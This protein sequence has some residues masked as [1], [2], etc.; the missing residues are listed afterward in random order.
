MF[1]VT[2]SIQ[3][4]STTPK[5]RSRQTF[6]Q[7]LIGILERNQAHTTSQQ[8]DEDLAFFESLIPAVRK[9]ND[10][11]KTEFR[12]EVL[13][14]VKKIQAMNFYVPQNVQSYPPFHS[15]HSQNVQ[16]PN[17]PTVNPWFS[18]S[19][20]LPSTSRQTFQAPS[21]SS[22]P[23]PATSVQALSPAESQMSQYSDLLE[24]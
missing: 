20:N 14:S 10:Y 19:L 18:Q 1:N 15:H 17:N 4:K 16:M 11:Q 5:T 6:E 23:S 24:I 22:E 9:F 12:L 8:K 3:P 13:N 7:Q 21:Q 2:P